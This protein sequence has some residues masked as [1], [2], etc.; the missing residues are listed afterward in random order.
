MH[1]YKKTK[2]NS[3]AFENTEC[4]VQGIQKYK[5]LFSCVTAER[6]AKRRQMGD[7]IAN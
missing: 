1:S 7:V 2:T 4:I 3:G 5:T 6:K